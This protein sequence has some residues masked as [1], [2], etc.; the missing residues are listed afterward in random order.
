MAQPPHLVH[1]PNG[2]E[3]GSVYGLWPMWV[4]HLPGLWYGCTLK[5]KKKRI[6]AVWRECESSNHL[7][8]LA[9]KI[10][11]TNMIFHLFF[12]SIKFLFNFNT[13]LSDKENTSLY[14]NFMCFYFLKLLFFLLTSL[15]FKRKKI[16]ISYK[17]WEINIYF[18]IF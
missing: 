17:C 1:K 9:C 5:K 13:I 8:I 6:E 4:W 14:K 7:K 12:K 10:L 2:L 16:P 3:T 18:Y 11:C 15:S